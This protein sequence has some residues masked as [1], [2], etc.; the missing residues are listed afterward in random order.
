MVDF[1]FKVVSFGHSTFFYQLCG[2]SHAFKSST[3]FSRAFPPFKIDILWAIWELFQNWFRPGS[4]L[5]P[6]PTQ[7]LAPVGRLKFRPL[8]GRY[9]KYGCRSGPPGWESI[10][11]LRKKVGIDSLESIHGL[12]KSLKI[13]ALYSS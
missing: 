6:I 2:L 1:F 12:L 13:W 7:F 10:P 5:V 3:C 11:G 8:V 4:Y 9:F